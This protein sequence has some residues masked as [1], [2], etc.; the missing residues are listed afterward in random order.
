MEWA[1]STDAPPLVLVFGFDNRTSEPL[2]DGTV[3]VVLG[4]ALKRSPRLYPAAGSSLRGLIA[5]EVPEA[6]GQDDLIGQ[7]IAERDRRPVA[8]IHGF[9]T[10]EGPG[11]SITISAKDGAS[12]AKI[13]E[14]TSHAASIGGITGTTADLACTV[15]T[16]LHDAPCDESSFGKTGL[17][18][19]MDANHEFVVGRA[20]FNNGNN[21]EAEPHFS[22][23]IEIDP[24]FSMAQLSLG[25]LMW[26]TG[27]AHLGLPHLDLALARQDQL[28]EREKWVVLATEHVM[29]D[30]LDDACAAYEQQLVRW[31]ADTSQRGNLA[32]TLFGAGHV[33]EAVA[34]AHLNLTEHPRNVIV[35][36]ELAE[37]NVVAGKLEEAARDAHMVVANFSSPPSVTHAAGAAAD[38]LL[39]RRIG[40]LELYGMLEGTDPSAHA[41]LLADFAMFEGRLIDARATLERILATQEAKSAATAAQS[42]S[43]T[44]GEV[45]LRLGDRERARAAAERAASSSDLVTLVRAG[46]VFARAGR[47]HEAGVVEKNIL[48]HTGQRAPLFARIVRAETLLAARVPGD[49]ILAL[50]EIGTGAGAALAHVILGEAQLDAGALDDAR[51]ELEGVYARPGALAFAFYDETSTL[52]YLPAVADLLARIDERLQRGQ[53]SR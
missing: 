10:Q 13:A 30:D 14:R 19:S 24:G 31:P 45:F 39:G 21:L 37:M 36:A 50:G 38:V 18:E 3:D 8:L 22:R 43:A 40:A 25:L 16:W 5:E 51:R 49:A 20:A 26:N 4:G 52:R 47:P 53:R 42:T 44:L 41:A 46:R 7:L 28:S 17:S 27:R 48:S 2:L 6:A 33:S 15:R 9:V 12:G 32:A 1:P 34:T 35:W 29:K 11:F 23:A